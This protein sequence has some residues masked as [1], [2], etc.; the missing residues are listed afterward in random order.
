MYLSDAVPTRSITEVLTSS[1]DNTIEIHSI[2]LLGIHKQYVTNI[3]NILFSSLR[4]HQYI[5][6]VLRLQNIYLF[7]IWKKMFMKSYQ[8]WSL[9]LHIKSIYFMIGCNQSL[10][11][12]PQLASVIF[13]SLRYLSE[14]ASWTRRKCSWHTN[15]FEKEPI[16]L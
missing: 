5:C 12:C 13:V 14:V 7:E 1:V 4:F 10:V 16:L 9:S 2:L 3:L 8:K 11:Y 6:T 15:N